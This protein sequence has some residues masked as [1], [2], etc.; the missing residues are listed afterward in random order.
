MQI[1]KIVGQDYIE[2]NF[3]TSKALFYPENCEAKQ[4]R[5][6]IETKLKID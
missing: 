4:L 5:E 2:M 3:S 1:N 6:N